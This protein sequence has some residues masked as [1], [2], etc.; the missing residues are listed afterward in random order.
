MRPLPVLYR[1]VLGGVLYDYAYPPRGTAQWFMMEHAFLM[2]VLAY[3]ER[4]D[5][6]P[7]HW[8]VLPRAHHPGIVHNDL[9]RSI[10]RWGE[11]LPK[12]RRD[13]WKS[14]LW[15]L[16]QELVLLLQS[17]VGGGTHIKRGIQNVKE[18]TKRVCDY[19]A[20]KNKRQFRMQWEVYL[21]AVIWDFKTI[22]TQGELRT[23]VR[24]LMRDGMSVGRHIDK[25]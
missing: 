23:E 16:T 25:I 17:M 4:L 21:N 8:G 15:E 5:H 2:A 24:N 12:E 11:L 13:E 14:L 20:P 7:G 22:R 3:T 6:T 19:W 1:N 10:H 18:I 9:R